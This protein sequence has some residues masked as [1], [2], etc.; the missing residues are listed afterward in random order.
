MKTLFTLTSAESR[1]LIAKAVVFSRNFKPLGK[2]PMS[3][4]AGGTT[5]AFLA[6]EI[7]DKDKEEIEPGRCTFGHQ[8]RQACFA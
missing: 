3:C 1:R 4:S 6:Q 8:Y 2:M 7:L 5:N